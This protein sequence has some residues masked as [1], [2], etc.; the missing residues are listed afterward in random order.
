MEAIPLRLFRQLHDLLGN[1]LLCGMYIL[2]CWV[3]LEENEAVD[4][5]GHRYHH[6]RHLG[7][8][9]LLDQYR[10]S[11]LFTWKVFENGNINKKRETPNV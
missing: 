6:L 10:V 5:R 8:H 3:L 7:N 11:T 2:R 9:Q 4:R 1:L